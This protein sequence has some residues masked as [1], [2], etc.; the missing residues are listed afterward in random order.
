M[1]SMS[2]LLFQLVQKGDDLKIS[3]VC[4]YFRELNWGLKQESKS[5]MFGPH[6]KMAVNLINKEVSETKLCGSFSDLEEVQFLV[7][8]KM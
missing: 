8:T 3:R 6:F 7:A 2:S 4:I 5:Q 1:C